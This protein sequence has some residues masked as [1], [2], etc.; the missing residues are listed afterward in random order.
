[1]QEFDAGKYQELNLYFKQKI[2]ELLESHPQLKNRVAEGNSLNLE[3][4]VECLTLNHQLRWKEFLELDQLK[5]NQDLQNHL[6]GKGTPLSNKDGFYR[7]SRP[8][9]DNPDKGMW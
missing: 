4:I 6:E 1:M 9:G 2:K 3:E 7:S 5:M 8:D